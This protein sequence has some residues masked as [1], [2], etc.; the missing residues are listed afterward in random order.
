MSHEKKKTWNKLW[1][2]LTIYASGSGLIKLKK[3]NLYNIYKNEKWKNIY[4]KTYFI[5]FYH[6]VHK[7]VAF[8]KN[9]KIYLFDKDMIKN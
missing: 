1:F 7:N 9:S 3:S 6:Y 8:P 4:F 2:I 5:R